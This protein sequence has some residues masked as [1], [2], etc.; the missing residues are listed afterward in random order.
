MKYILSILL[1]IIVYVNVC[2]IA[3]ADEAQIVIKYAYNDSELAKKAAKAAETLKKNSIHLGLI[4]KADIFQGEGGLA[5]LKMGYIELH[6]ANAKVLQHLIPSVWVKLTAAKNNDDRALRE[7]LSK[8]GFSL[9]KTYFYKDKTIVLISNG[10]V[11]PST[12]KLLSD[13]L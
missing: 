12:Q 4:E 6:A 7:A 13:L 8:L 10:S 5:A 11:A 3:Y 9:I 2:A 1:S